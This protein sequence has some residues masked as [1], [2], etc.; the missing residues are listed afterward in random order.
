MH[1]KDLKT[2]D[3]STYHKQYIDLAGDLQ[4]LKLLDHNGTKTIAFFENISEEKMETAYANGKWTIKELLQHIIDTER[5]FSYRALRFARNDQ[6]L[7]PGY[8]Q[9]DYVQ[10]SQANK[11]SKTDL[12]A[13]FKNVRMATITLFKSFSKETL[14]KKGTASSYKTTVAAIGFI[15][16]GHANHHINIVKERYL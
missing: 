14:L 5:I 12:L 1:V 2:T 15:N 3:F 4:L 10:P 13:D 7:L 6:T 9:D 11:Q 8:E 16:V